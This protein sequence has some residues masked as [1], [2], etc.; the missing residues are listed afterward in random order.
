MSHASVYIHSGVVCGGYFNCLWYVSSVPETP[1]LSL[2]QGLCFDPPLHTEWPCA[3]SPGV[4]QC[5]PRRSM[6]TLCVCRA[7]EKWLYTYVLE[8]SHCFLYNYIFVGMYV[9]VIPHSS[10]N[11]IYYMRMLNW[12]WD[13][14]VSVNGPAHSCILK[15]DVI[16]VLHNIIEGCTI[17][18]TV[19]MF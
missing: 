18:I 19:R 15:C 2:W 1:S 7:L 17:H 12:W 8:Q 4:P 16:G 13:L 10:V 5:K 3:K 14:C 6:L 11:V 9:L